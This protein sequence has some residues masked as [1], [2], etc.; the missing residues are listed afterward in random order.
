M[1]GCARLLIAGVFLAAGCVDDPG[2]AGGDDEEPL[3]A[4]DDSA[5][6]TAVQELSSSLTL[7]TTLV[8]TDN[9]N[10]RTGPSTSY[11][12]IEVI[13][14]GTPVRV[15]FHTP[16]RAPCYNIGARGGVGGSSGLSL[17]VATPP[18]AH[19]LATSVVRKI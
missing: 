10:L 3:P 14:A 11:H 12:V 1:M 9:L 7:G 6:G 16:P 8:T 15:V 2:D 13:P 19:T 17:K 5:T 18:A 4:A